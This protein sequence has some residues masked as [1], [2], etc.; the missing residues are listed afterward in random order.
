MSIK[1]KIEFERSPAEVLKRAEKAVRA[2]LSAAAKSWHDEDMEDHFTV[3][4]NTKYDY[5]P[6]KGDDEPP[7]IQKMVKVN[8]HSEQR[9]MRSV[10][11]QAYSWKKRRRFKHNKPLVWTGES[12][13][14]A[15]AAVKLST[16]KSGG[17][18]LQGIAAMPQLPK[19]FYQ[20]NKTHTQINK[21]AELTRTTPEELTR[22]EQVVID[23]AKDVLFNAKA[24]KSVRVK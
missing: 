6:R 2:G 22:L 10:P 1:A 9:V 7:T 3:A 5:A 11:N 13:R 4:A 24:R 16:R 14:G 8:Q 15:K 21:A 12:E 18:V 19:H 23:V 20:Y 17:S